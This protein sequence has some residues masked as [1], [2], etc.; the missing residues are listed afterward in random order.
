M[1]DADIHLFGE[2]LRRYRVAA[3]LSQEALAEAAGLSPRAISALERG[4]RRAPQQETVRLLA[5][6]LALAGE[7]RALLEQAVTRRRGPRGTPPSPDSPSTTPLPSPL[8]SLIGRGREVAALAALL[9]QPDVRLL[10]VTGPGGVGKTRLALRVAEVVRG[11]YADGVAFVPLAALSDPGLVATAIARALG[12][13]EGGGQAARE[14]VR[15]YLRDKR[16]LLVLD[17]FEHVVASADL[18]VDLLQ[19]C[20]AL[21]ALVTSRAALRVAGEQE[22]AAPPLALPDEA[23]P[24]DLAALS[25]VASVRLFVERA[26]RVAPDFA[27]TGANAAAV[28]MIVARLDGLPLAIELAAA[29]VKALAPDALLARL[30]RASGDTSLHLLTGGPRDLPERQRAMRDAIGWSY[31][32]LDAG[33]QALFRRQAVFAGGWTLEAAEA[34]CARD[35]SVL[36]DVLDGLASLVDKSLVWPDGGRG[37]RF[38]MLRTIREYGLERLGESKEAGSAHEAHALYYLDLAGQANE[39]LMGP[40]QQ[41]LLERLEREADNLREALR[42][43]LESG[44]SGAGLRL[45]GALWRSWRMQGRVG[46]GR[47]WLD[48]ALSLDARSGRADD[49]P[50]RALCLT[51]SGTLAYMQGDYAAAARFF[52]HGLALYQQLGDGPGIANVLNNLG[53]LAHVRGEYARSITFHEESLAIKRSRGDEWGVALSLNNIADGVMELGDYARAVALYEESLGL[54]RAS[55]DTYTTA[56][57]IN[58]LAGAVLGQGDYRRAVDLA[59]ESAALMR[60]IDS[61]LGVVHALTTSGEAA[62]A[63]DEYGR[64]ADLFGE[65]LPL[66]LKLGDKTNMAVCVEGMAAVA[67]ADGRAEQAARLCGAAE[68]LREATGAPMQ[69]TV[70]WLYERTLATVRAALGAH[71]FAAVWVA[72]MALPLERAID[73]SLALDVS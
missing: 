33:E 9:E 55:G 60:T 6:A 58:N 23:D 11:D 50:A 24:S 66:A 10:T 19:G 49:A 26:R 21:C 28:A 47:A 2:L 67:V 37:D 59:V 62:L 5:D 1:V 51:G 48:Q 32:L 34:V 3:G 68:A 20:L 63:L 12:V 70:R 17:N 71:R 72:G 29:R 25:G 43:T 65:S 36:L 7:D 54:L 45:A 35:G 8:T 61:P 41:A 73:E 30:N 52:E 44:D 56:A 27:L 46:E 31:D 39:Q 15:I 13:R 64:A 18:I 14:S 42:W 69:P 22:F 16:M 57:V 40:E 4:E 38:A 53:A